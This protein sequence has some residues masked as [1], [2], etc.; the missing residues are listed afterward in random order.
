MSPD[1]GR[2]TGKNRDGLHPAILAIGGGGSSQL[3]STIKPL[4]G[5]DIAMWIG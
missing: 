1:S 5:A 3:S 4:P 2:I